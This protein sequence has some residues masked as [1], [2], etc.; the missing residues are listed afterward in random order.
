MGADPKPDD[1]ILLLNSQ[2]A[3]ANTNADRIHLMFLADPFEL[4]AGVIRMLLPESVT[5]AGTSP[6]VIGKMPKTL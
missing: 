5:P 1:D 2:G 6:G 4:Q 3:P